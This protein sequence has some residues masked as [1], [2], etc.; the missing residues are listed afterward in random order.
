M[1]TLRNGGNLIG[2]NSHL[3]EILIGLLIVLAVLLDK[4]RRK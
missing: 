1:A 4:R 2:I 3:Q